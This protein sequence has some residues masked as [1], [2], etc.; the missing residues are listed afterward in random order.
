[1]T[2]IILLDQLSYLQFPLLFYLRNFSESYYY[3]FLLV[4]FAKLCFLIYS[5]V[6]L[7]GSL[8]GDNILYNY[9]KGN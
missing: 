4:F 5:A 3:L 8:I 7:I 6:R 1:M 9:L 2:V